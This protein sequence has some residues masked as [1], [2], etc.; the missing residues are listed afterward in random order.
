[1]KVSSNLWLPF[2]GQFFSVSM[3]TWFSD[4]SMFYKFAFLTKNGEY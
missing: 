4:V 3:I 1:L 2:Q